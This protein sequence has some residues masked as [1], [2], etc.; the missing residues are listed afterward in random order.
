MMC[1][2]NI[3][4]RSHVPNFVLTIIVAFVLACSSLPLA[5]A[6]NKD[7]QETVKVGF[8]VIED[9]NYLDVNGDWRGYDVE[10]LLKIA[11]YANFH[12]DLIAFDNPTDAIDALRNGKVDTVCN[13]MHDSQRDTEFIFTEYPVSLSET[14]VFTSNSNTLLSYGSVEQLNGLT[15]GCLSGSVAGDKLAN[16]CS[17]RG[18]AI[19]IAYFTSDDDMLDAFDFGTIAAAVSGSK[20]PDGHKAI[21]SYQSEPGYLMFTST[22]TTLKND[23][24]SALGTIVNEEPTY[25]DE[26]YQ[27]YD[28]VN[29]SDSISLTADEKDYIAQQSVVKVALP[30]NAE[31]FSYTKNSTLTGIVPKYYD[32]LA[33]KSG[34]KFEYVGY[35]SSDSALKA[36]QSGQ[37]DVLGFSYYDIITTAQEGLY[38]TNPYISLHCVLIGNKDVSEVKTCAVTTRT[39]EALREQMTRQGYNIKFRA[40]ANMEECYEAVDS[41]QVD[42]AIGSMTSGSWLINQHS[43]PHVTLVTLPG[44]HLD[45]SGCVAKSD[46]L[47]SILNKSIKAS[48]PEIQRLTA[49]NTVTD[50]S[51]IQTVIENT[52][53]G[54][55]MT[56][57]IVLSALVIALI[58]ALFLLSRRNRERAQ[59]AAREAENE[60]LEAKLAAE[61]EFNKRRSDFFSNLSHD[62]RTPLNAIIGFSDLARDTDDRE[63]EK[64]YLSKI[65]TSGNILLGLIDDSLTVSK[66][67][68]GKLCLNEKPTL[69]SDV[70]E[71]VIVPIQAFAAGRG[72][73]FS[74]D[75]PQDDPVLI[76]DK[77]NTQKIFLN[78]LTN[79]VKYTPRGGK[80]LFSISFER[81]PDMT[82][83]MTSVV[84][85]TGVGIDAKFLPHI[86]E[87]FLQEIRDNDQS[88][89]SG[90]GLTIVKDFVDL[91][92]GTI[93]VASEKDKG[94]TF[95]VKFNVVEAG[96]DSVKK[97]TAE[98]SRKLVSLEG[99][100]ILLCEDNDLNAEITSTVLANNGAQ[101]LLAH[102]G[103]EGLQIF[104]DS[105]PD[106]I[107]C[108]LMDLRMPIMDGYET[109]RKI[110]ALARAD[111][112]TVPVIA[113]SADAFA[114]DER[115]SLDAGMN[116][117]L[118]KPVDA[119]I[120]LNTLGKLIN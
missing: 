50:H 118:S 101:V 112:Q 108:I 65:H 46:E 47:F 62:M 77:L 104:E 36:V 28:N 58:I 67:N 40:Y 15:V 78:L 16:Y 48:E 82:L 49:E 116:A 103:S 60:R 39:L 29:S 96:Q 31:P 20:V 63:L 61:T 117:Y 37:A 7:T 27:K 97:I 98:H 10:M 106:S 71:E 64:G 2:G 119:S 54:I 102:D 18:V 34:L 109:T 90:L 84:Q 12:L 75:L 4:K 85:D 32:I 59:I 23:F 51:N 87:P 94:T 55:I 115:R 45:M 53:A 66:S 1:W 73:V 38:I 81:L 33:Q 79:A 110:R 25:I 93:D 107:C 70:L 42:A 19:K 111:A 80:V 100:T 74:T 113:L 76:I 89:G 120:L 52:P 5:H 30:K 3:W 83:H 17:Q 26:L 88:T 99:L 11:Q 57:T 24:D 91:M 22:Q 68:S 56:V 95:T 9:Y 92:G 72:I 44:T 69:L 43:L 41:G 6:S 13:F 35:D 114:E 8:I 14:R 86:Y 105:A 21:F